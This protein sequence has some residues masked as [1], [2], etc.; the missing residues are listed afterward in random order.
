MSDNVVKKKLVQFGK[1]F[2]GFGFKGEMLRQSTFMNVCYGAS[3]LAFTPP[4]H[5]HERLLQCLCT[6]VLVNQYF[7]L[8]KPPM[9]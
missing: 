8:S 2:T 4:E 9:Y 7:L 1:Y 3:E 5:I 6:R